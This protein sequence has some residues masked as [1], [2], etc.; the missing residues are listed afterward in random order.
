[1]LHSFEYAVGGHSKCANRCRLDYK[2]IWLVQHQEFLGLLIFYQIDV[3]AIY[4]GIGN[5]LF[6][7][8]YTSICLM[9]MK[10]VQK[11]N[12]GWARC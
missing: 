1:M 11:W 2:M 10:T 4:L 9:S 3:W 6:I 12:G 8:N 5:T 7:I